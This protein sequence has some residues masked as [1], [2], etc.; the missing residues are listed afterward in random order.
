MKFLC[1]S[2]DEQMKI[3]ETRGPDEGSVTLIFQCPGCGWEVGMLTN[4]YETQIVQSLNVRIGPQANESTTSRCPVGQARSSSS[5]HWTPEATERLHRVPTFVREM[6][7]MGV[8][9]FA[10]AHGYDVITEEVMTAARAE[11]GM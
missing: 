7:R 10:S 3:K 5:I 8:E 4:A 9:E 2:C 1:V 11:R 6:A